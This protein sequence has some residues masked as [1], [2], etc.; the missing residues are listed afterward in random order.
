M[1]TSDT[2]AITNLIGRYAELVDAGDFDG[3]GRL[4]TDA[5]FT[6]SGPALQGSDAVAAMLRDTV[7]RYDDGTPRTHH[8][9]T[10]HVVEVDDDG[11]T[12]HARSAVTIF[13]AVDGLPLQPIAAGRYE[14]TFARHRG[15]WR[16]TTRTVRIHLVGDVSRHLRA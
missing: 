13:Q 3:V 8:V 12:A 10:N 4:F 1:T 11:G 5:T 7:I 9:T 2:T 6:G 15:A 14:D 16:F